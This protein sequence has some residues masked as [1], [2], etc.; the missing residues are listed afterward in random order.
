MLK[1]W[2]K[3]DLVNRIAKLRGYRSYLEI[4]TDYT[5]RRYGEIDRNLLTTCHRMM[6]RCPPRHSGR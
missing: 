1:Q 2:T 5:G 4:C 3:A 6:Y